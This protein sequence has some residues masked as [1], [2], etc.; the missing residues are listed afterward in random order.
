M[1]KLF[2]DVA[3]LSLVI[4]IIIRSIVKGFVGSV[5]KLYKIIAVVLLTVLLGGAVVT[6]CR[7]LFVAGW[8]DGR[9][10]AKFAAS[11]AGEVDK[12]SFESLMDTLPT[13]FRNIVPI[14]QLQEQYLSLSG[15]ATDAAS[16]LG[17]TVDNALITVVSNI[18]GYVITF[19]AAFLVLSLVAWILE[20]FVQLPVLKQIDK[21]F[22]FF[23][24]VACAYLWA[25]VVVC[26]VGFFVDETFINS[27]YVFRF[28]YNCGLFTHR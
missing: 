18:I 13:F 14:E 8:F 6:M 10:A 15:G 21:L 11:A 2:L 12:V 24:G 20:K 27:T 5:F 19:V 28:V 25:S 17:E 4:F 1:F 16:K 23:W 7:E 3:L 9:F 22:G 26:V